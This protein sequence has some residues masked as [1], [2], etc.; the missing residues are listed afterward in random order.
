MTGLITLTWVYILSE[1][2]G[3]GGTIRPFSSFWGPKLGPRA[4]FYLFLEKI[5]K[6]I[7]KNRKFHSKWAKSEEFFIL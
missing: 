6:K 7:K 1:H 4:F 5:K 3:G 2:W